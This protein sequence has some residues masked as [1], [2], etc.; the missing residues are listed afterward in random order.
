MYALDGEVGVHDLH[1]V[2]VALGNTLEH[3]LNVGDGSA[4][5]SNVGLVAEPLLSA[6]DL[7]LLDQLEVDLEVGKVLHE[8]ATGT[9]DGHATTAD[10]D[11]HCWR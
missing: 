10:L 6:N 3:V 1:A 8:S 5:S 11:L 2:Q 9:S 4:D 7:A